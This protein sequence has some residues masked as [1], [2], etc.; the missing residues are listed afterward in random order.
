MEE[1]LVVIP[2]DKLSSS[3]M[4]VIGIVLRVRGIVLVVVGMNGDLNN[5]QFIVK[6]KQ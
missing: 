2:A 6:L 4:R 3:L 1:H 5:S